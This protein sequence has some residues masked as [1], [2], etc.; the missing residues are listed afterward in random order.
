MIL[1]IDTSKTIAMVI[2]WY[3]FKPGCIAYY[4]NRLPSIMTVLAASI[5]IHAIL[6]MMQ[7]AATMFTMFIGRLFAEMTS[8]NTTVVAWPVSSNKRGKPPDLAQKLVG[9]WTIEGNSVATFEVKCW[10]VQVPNDAWDGEILE[11]PTVH[12]LGRP[13]AKMRVSLPQ[14]VQPGANYECMELRLH[15]PVVGYQSFDIATLSS[16]D[17]IKIWPFA[18]TADAMTADGGSTESMRVQLIED[19]TVLEWTNSCNDRP[20]SFRWKKVA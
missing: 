18:P 16:A 2:F 20:Q 7:T 6:D 17:N 8:E 1:G 9:Q 4:F 3:T 12:S 10:D 11:V 14:G 15:H 5:L 13:Q 19:D